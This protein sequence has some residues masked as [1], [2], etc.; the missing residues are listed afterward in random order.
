MIC[1]GFT[2]DNIVG[3]INSTHSNDIRA[4]SD[5]LMVPSFFDAFFRVEIYSTLDRCTMKGQHLQRS[6]AWLE[7]W[8]WSDGHG[9]EQTL[10]SSQP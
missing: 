3:E 10:L 9:R 6:T 8:L 7:G 5:I 2:L 4:T 1:S